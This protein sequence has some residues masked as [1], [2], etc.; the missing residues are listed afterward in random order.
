MFKHKKTTTEPLLKTRQSGEISVDFVHTK[1][2][3]KELSSMSVQ[4]KYISGLYKN[5]AIEYCHV[6][7]KKT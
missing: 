2:L 3:L 4:V 6:T 1:I 5:K 7:Y